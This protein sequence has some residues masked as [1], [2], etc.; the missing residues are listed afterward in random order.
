MVPTAE[1]LCSPSEDL[2]F[3]SVPVAKVAE[4][5]SKV[6]PTLMKVSHARRIMEGTVF[7]GDKGF[8]RRRRSAARRLDRPDTRPPAPL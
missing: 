6:I 5:S 8:T 2:P 4:P 7:L 1:L 3:L